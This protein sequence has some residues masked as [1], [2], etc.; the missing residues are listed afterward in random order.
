[1]LYFVKKI[2]RVLA[3]FCNFTAN[4]NIKIKYYGKR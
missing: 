4:T 1:M 3:F 2:Y